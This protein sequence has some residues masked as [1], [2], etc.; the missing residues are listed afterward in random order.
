MRRMPIFRRTSLEV[1]PISHWLF[2][3]RGYLLISGSQLRA[4][5]RPTNHR[6]PGGLSE[7]RDQRRLHPRL[8]IRASARLL[9]HADVAAR[10]ARVDDGLDVLRRVTGRVR[11][12]ASRS[13]RR[14]KAVR[15]HGRSPQPRRSSCRCH[16]TM[17]C[18]RLMDTE[19]R[20]L[21]EP[22]AGGIGKWSNIRSAR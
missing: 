21:M 19:S 12:L 22:K 9:S 1:R 6:N 4:L 17:S 20:S 13:P 8:R 14:T 15:R 2:V 10:M 16:S 11:A 7:R 5:M 3:S 18:R